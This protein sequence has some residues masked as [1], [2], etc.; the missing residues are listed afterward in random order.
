MSILDPKE[1]PG[2]V[3]CLTQQHSG[4]YESE[5]IIFESSKSK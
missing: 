3:V 2:T 5:R 1:S 4:R